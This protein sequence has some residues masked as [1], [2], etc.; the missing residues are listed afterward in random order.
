LGKPI[1]RRRSKGKDN[2]KMDLRKYVGQDVSELC[3]AAVSGINVAELSCCQ[4]YGIVYF[5]YILRMRTY[6]KVK[7][8]V[9][10]F[11]ID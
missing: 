11:L 6:A 10:V 3:P 1:K 9:S 5:I 7:G 8:K 4:K 2:I